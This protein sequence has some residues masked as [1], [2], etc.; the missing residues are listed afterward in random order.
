MTEIPTWLSRTV[1]DPSVLTDRHVLDLA[2]KLGPRGLQSFIDIHSHTAPYRGQRITLPE[3]VAILDQLRR[4]A[5][6]GI[7]WAAHVRS[8]GG[9]HPMDWLEDEVEA[10]QQI[11][12]HLT[13]R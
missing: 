10:L 7:D 6:D 8:I 5:R 11:I 9:D 3:A 13:D 4:A 2:L 1:K 12:D